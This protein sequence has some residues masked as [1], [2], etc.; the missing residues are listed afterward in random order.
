V[1][2]CLSSDQ[3]HTKFRNRKKANKD[4]EKPIHIRNTYV[5]FADMELH[6]GTNALRRIDYSAE[7]YTKREEGMFVVL[8]THSGLFFN[9][10]VAAF[11]HYMSLSVEA[12]IWDITEPEQAYVVEKKQYLN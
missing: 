9:T 7:H 12:V 11:I 5:T 1:T 10:L 8:T 3:S 6:S 2:R 4:D